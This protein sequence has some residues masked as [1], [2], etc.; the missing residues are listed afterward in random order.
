MKLKHPNGAAAAWDPT[1]QLATW[2]GNDVAV[3]IYPSLTHTLSLEPRN[4]RFSGI[5]YI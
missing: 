1:Q 5:V 3:D 2:V 4:K